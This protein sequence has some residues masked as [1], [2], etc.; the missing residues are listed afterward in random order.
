MAESPTGLVSIIMESL[1]QVDIDLLLWINHSWK[2]A[3]MDHVMLFCSDKYTWIPFYAV[4]L[5]FLYKSDPK[6]IWI[7]LIVLACCIALA[8]QI[9]SSLFKPYF[10]RL[11]PC[12]NDVLRPQLLLIEGVCGGM[13]GF[14]SSHA[15][16]TFAVFT[17]FTLK[18]VFSKKIWICI[19]FVWA[20]I[21][22]LSRVYLGVHFPGDVFCGS[23]IGVAVTYFI[24]W[25]ERMIEQ[26]YFHET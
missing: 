17:F 1:Q 18:N 22:S 21:V 9:A 14:V 6:K 25:I 3:W 13:Y 2:S 15:A 4:L 10:E 23:L 24:L 16:N 5:F 7:N 12:N 19:L 8:D 20:L 26:K 11:R